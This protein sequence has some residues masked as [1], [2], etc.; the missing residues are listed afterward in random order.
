M[1]ERAGPATRAYLTQLREQ[2]FLQIKDGYVDTSA[3][4][5]KDTKWQDVA[6]LKPETITEEEVRLNPSMKRL[7][8]MFPVP[9]TQKTGAS[10]S[11]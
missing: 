3:A 7:L 9:G 8:G 1:A 10:S 5:G 6:A 11:R 4:P 2:A